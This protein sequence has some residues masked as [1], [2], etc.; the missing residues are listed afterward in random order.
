MQVPFKTSFTVLDEQ[1][2]IKTHAG[3]LLKT[4]YSGTTRDRIFSVAGRFL[5]ILVLE[6]NSGT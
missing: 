2:K 3:V 6:L 4:A 1:H 5:L